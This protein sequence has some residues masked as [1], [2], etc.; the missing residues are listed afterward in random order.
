MLPRGEYQRCCGFFW[1][2]FFFPKETRCCW[3]CEVFAGLLLPVT[4][5][6]PC[7]RG[8]SAPNK[9]RGDCPGARRARPRSVRNQPGSGQGEDRRGCCPPLSRQLFPGTSAM[10]F[11][12]PLRVFPV[13][14]GRLRGACSPLRM[15]TGGCA[16]ELDALGRESWVC[17]L[18]PS[19]E[20][21]PRSVSPVKRSTSAPALR[22]AKENFTFGDWSAVSSSGLPSS[23]K[24]RSYWRES[25]G[26]L[27]G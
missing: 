17:V 21:F 27:R 1:F 18:Q 22:W 20:A 14:P 8:N 2:V 23:R 19:H 11:F 7:P 9:S 16:G 4:H 26:G 6:V 25:S 13:P 5:R 12:H 10:Q 3:R 15:G 24:M